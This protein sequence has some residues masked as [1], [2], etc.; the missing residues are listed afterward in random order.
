[1]GRRI[2]EESVEEEVVDGGCSFGRRVSLGVARIPKFERRIFRASLLIFSRFKA[3]HRITTSLTTSPRLHRHS[4][5]RTSLRSHVFHR[6]TRTFSLRLRAL[7]SWPISKRD[8]RR[9]L[10]DQSPK[11][12]A[13][14]SDRN[15]SA[16]TTS[17]DIP[18][19]QYPLSDSV[20]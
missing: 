3:I 8:N 12:D 7:Q 14:T 19:A 15:S 9:L 6:L 2:V 10:S 13:R 18:G 20:L 11:L 5:T 17:C 4:N 1:M 16:K